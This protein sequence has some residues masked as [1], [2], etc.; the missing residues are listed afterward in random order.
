MKKKSKYIG[1]AS[2]LCFVGAF[3]LFSGPTI[4]AVIC[5]VAASKRVENATSWI[6]DMPVQ[7]TPFQLFL[8]NLLFPLLQIGIPIILIIVSL[9]LLIVFIVNNKKRG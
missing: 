2:L 3:V 4:I 6:S 5:N 1:I 8:K 9:V 7:Y